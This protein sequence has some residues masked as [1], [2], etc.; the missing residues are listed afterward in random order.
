MLCRSVPGTSPLAPI[1]RGRGGGQRLDCWTQRGPRDA[2]LLPACLSHPCNCPVRL[3]G[4]RELIAL[5]H[6]Q[7]DSWELQ[8]AF[9]ALPGRAQGGF[10]RPAFAPK[11]VHLCPRAQGASPCQPGHLR[12]IFLPVPG[13]PWGDDRA[14]SGCWEQGGMG[15]GTGQLDTRVGREAGA[16]TWMLPGR[17]GLGLLG[18]QWLGHS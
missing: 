5:L 10:A 9:P 16:N 6:H 11:L 18:P 17:P 8:I 4:G 7:R 14:A 2:G 1:S 15:F 12:Q 13:L 3:G